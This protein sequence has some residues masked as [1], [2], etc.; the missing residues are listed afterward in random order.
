MNTP[1]LQKEERKK[2]IAILAG[3]HSQFM[4][5]SWAS[6]DNEEF[7]YVDSPHRAFGTNFDGYQVIGSFY[8]KKDAFELER[9]VKSRI[10]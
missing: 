2:R 5:Y 8:D 7:V 4:D 6:K 10:I 3:S 1:K 9:I